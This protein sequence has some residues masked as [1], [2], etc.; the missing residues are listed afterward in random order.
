MSNIVGLTKEFNDL[1]EA[2]MFAKAQHNTIVSLSKKIQKLEE[3]KT[4][5]EK[6][7]ASSTP[8]IPSE[9]TNSLIQSNMGG[10]LTDDEESICR[11]QLRKLRD[12]S[13]LDELTL[14]EAKRV[15]IYT[16][17]LIAK[18]NQPKTVVIE[19]KNIPNDQLLAAFEELEN[20]ETRKET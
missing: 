5:L 13:L 1:M 7:L 16:K 20:S 10:I 12:K 9:K 4:H 3:E 8:L 15:E 18:A 19:S 2:N 11:M 14:E 6:L 17:I